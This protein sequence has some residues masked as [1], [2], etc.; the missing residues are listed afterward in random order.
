MSYSLE[1]MIQTTT[2]K[3]STARYSEYGIAG[4]KEV[5]PT[6]VQFI[7]Y[8]LKIIVFKFFCW[9]LVDTTCI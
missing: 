9:S 4:Y 6:F 7:I 5:D 2:R 8:L 3:P 1:F